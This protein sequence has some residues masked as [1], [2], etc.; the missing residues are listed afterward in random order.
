MIVTIRLQK[1]VADEAEAKAYEAQVKAAAG[2]PKSVRT[3][4]YRLGEEQIIKDRAAIEA[5]KIIVRPEVIAEVTPIIKAQTIEDIVTG[6]IVDP[7]ITVKA[8]EAEPK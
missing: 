1:E 8:A 2:D 4:Q 6:K 3:S 5:A 7:R